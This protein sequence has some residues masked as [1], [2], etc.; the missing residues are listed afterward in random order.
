MKEYRMEIRLLLIEKLE[1]P[2]RGI[3]HSEVVLH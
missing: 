2:H 3:S 1:L